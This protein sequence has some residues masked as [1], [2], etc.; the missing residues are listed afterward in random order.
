MHVPLW[1]L[2]RRLPVRYLPGREPRAGGGGSLGLTAGGYAGQDDTEPRVGRQLC[3]DHRMGR[4]TPLRDLYLGIP[5]EIVP[6]SGL[7]SGVE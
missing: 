7:P 1:S 2:A 4:R 5:A 3:A 6:L